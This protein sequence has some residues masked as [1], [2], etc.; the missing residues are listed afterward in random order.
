MNENKEAAIKIINTPEQ[1]QQHAD[2]LR[3]S[4]KSIAFVPTMGCLHE[5][6]LSLI[7]IAKIHGDYTVLSIF[8]N[9]AQ[10]GANEDFDSYPKQFEK[11][12]RAAE[13]EGVDT[14]FAP[15]KE[16][17]YGNGYETY[18][19]L[20]NLPHHLCGL[21]RPGHFRGVA[22]VVTKLFNIVKPHAAVFGEKD[23]QQL[24]VIRRMT[25]DLNLDVKIIG[26]PIVREPDG[27]AMSSRNIYLSDDQRPSALSLYQSLL[28]AKEMIGKGETRAARII[29]KVSRHIESLPE[30]EIDYVTLSDPDTLDEVET[31]DGTVLLAL[32]VRVGGKC[33][34]IDNMVI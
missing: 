9:P 17:L 18:V 33:R 5:G 29:E 15:E 8:V 21:F 32:A 24:A 4:G 12:A 34:L 3:C 6:H 28:M 30:T 19:T 11:D 31:I 27:L 16:S 14:I 26:A 13:A 7:R 22:T 10:F 20:E 2:A 23:F 1:M 25:S